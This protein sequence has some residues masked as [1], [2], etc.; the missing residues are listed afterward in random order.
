MPFFVIFETN[1]ASIEEVQRHRSSHLDYIGAWHKKGKIFA[2]GRF[3]DGTGG[4]IIA[5]VGSTEEAEEI[6][7]NDP[8]IA[9]RI[10]N[11]TI[12]PWDKV[13]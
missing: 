9:K 6:A 1:I 5:S 2:A 10:R 13:F 8:Y 11:F 7:R 12:R 3:L 4:M